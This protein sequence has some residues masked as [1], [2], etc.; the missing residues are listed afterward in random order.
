MSEHKNKIELLEKGALGCKKSQQAL[1]I[2]QRECLD[3]LQKNQNL[4]WNKCIK[5]LLDKYLPT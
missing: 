2:K 3:L 1:K 4:R 5:I